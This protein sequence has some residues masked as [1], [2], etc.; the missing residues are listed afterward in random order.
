MNIFMTGATGVLGRYTVPRLKA[1]GHRIRALSRSEA[2]DGT[3]LDMGVESVRGDLFD[4]EFIRTATQ[5]CEAIL[6]FATRIP[7]A[8]K[9]RLRSAWEENDR[10]RTE[11][12]RILV[13]AAL[14]S[15]V[16]TI[17][18]PSVV[19]LYPDG[20]GSWI[21]EDAPVSP[22][23]HVRSTVTAEEEIARF[24]AVG[25]RGISLRMGRF[26]SPRSWDAVDT[27]N[28]ARNG[29][30]MIPGRKG[31]FIP[32]IWV[33]DAASAVVA[34]LDRAA[35]GVWNIVDNEP[36]RLEGHQAILARTVG[37][38]H[39]VSLPRPLVRL[40]IGPSISET[41]ERSQRVSNC[42]FREATGW[43]PSVPSA[44]EGWPLI[45]AAAG[46]GAQTLPEKGAMPA[47]LRGTR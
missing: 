9:I 7:P 5:D 34:A 6:H 43:S 12:T 23:S 41:F 44:R 35:G 13:E 42:R 24:Q 27:V 47:E 18:Y 25:R 17:L 39:L 46:V 20:G 19:F 32:M 31:A 16:G 45:A 28:A 4:A 11:G 21:D 26:Y 1:A 29:L 15:S 33:D 30:S 8:A 36:L 3:L 10:I 40:A 38:R 2:N 22:T 14:Q 37:R